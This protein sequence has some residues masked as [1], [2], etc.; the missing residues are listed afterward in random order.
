MSYIGDT[1]WKK[2]KKLFRISYD[3]IN[4]FGIRYF[5]YVMR[6]EYEKQGFSMFSPDEKPL[7][8]VSN[9]LFQEKYKVCILKILA[10]IC[11]VIQ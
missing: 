8:A 6:Q 2:L 3:L 11:I 10:K 9:P 4:Q 1:P 7:D 5:I